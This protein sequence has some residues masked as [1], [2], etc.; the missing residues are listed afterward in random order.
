[1]RISIFGM[2][3]VGAVS[4]ACLSEM[5][6]DVIGVDTNRTKTDLLNTGQS[7]IVEKGV[8]SRIAAAVAA[9]KLHSTN[10]PAD[11]VARTDISFISVGTPSDAN[12]SPT[13]SIIDSVIHDIASALRR[14]SS[15]HAVVVRSTVLPGTT[16]GHVLEALVRQSGRQIGDGLELCFNPEFLREGSAVKDFYAPPFTVVGSI[17]EQG[18]STLESIYDGINA[19]FVRTSCGIAES[20]KYISNSYH[21]VKITFAN[22]I[23]V[24]LKQLGIDSRESMKLFCQDTILNISPAYLRPGFAFGGSCLP[25]ELRALESLARNANIDLPMISQLLQSNHAH[26]ERAFDMITRHGRSQ[27]ALFGLA[28]KPGTDD[29]RESPL[30]ALAERLI[31][32]GYELSIY[33]KSVDL[34]RLMGANREYI[35]KEIPHLEKLLVKHPREALEGAKTIVIG[36]VGPA[37]IDAINDHTT[38]AAIID[39]QGVEAIKSANTGRYEGICW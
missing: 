39:L 15:E 16:E 6:H 26:V 14:K 11:A 3:Y 4:A 17:A 22:E 20:L 1:M 29:L 5:G 13:L 35:E 38:T 32:R 31:G 18:Y 10:D 9:G 7:P 12:G 24:L 21:A 27:I 2:G 36:H 8:A 30:V 34:G 19:P 23:G 37:E 33:D 25:K 28:F